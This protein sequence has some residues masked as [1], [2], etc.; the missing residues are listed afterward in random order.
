MQ[1]EYLLEPGRWAVAGVYLDDVGQRID[2]L[3]TTAIRHGPQ[4][5]EVE[6]ELRLLTEPPT[7]FRHLYRVR[8]FHSGRSDT[9]WRSDNPDLG[10][11]KGQFALVDD[12]LIS[13]Y[14][15]TSGDFHGMET[16]RRIEA[17]RYEGRGALFKGDE[18]LSSWAVNLVCED[19]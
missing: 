5:W 12:T 19:Q 8:P 4:H 15:S 14:R 1:H 10:T 7:E 6:G 9:S 13:V 3:G 2:V 18:R 11:L 17:G 16:L